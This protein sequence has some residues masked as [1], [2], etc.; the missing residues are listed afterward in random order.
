MRGRL[1]LIVG[2]LRICKKGATRHMV[3]HKN[4]MSFEQFEQ[5]SGLLIETCLLGKRDN[6]YE[7]TQAGLEFLETCVRLERSMRVCHF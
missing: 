5:Y 4:N 7:T 1:E 3:I 6:L 2:M